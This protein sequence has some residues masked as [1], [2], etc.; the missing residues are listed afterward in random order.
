MVRTQRPHNRQ[1]T[2]ERHGHLIYTKAKHQYKNR[3]TRKKETDNAENIGKNRARQGYPSQG[4]AEKQAPQ[5]QKPSIP[6]SQN[7][8]RNGATKTAL[9]KREKISGRKTVGKNKGKWHSSANPRYTVFSRMTRNLTIFEEKRQK[10][11]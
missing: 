1:K 11:G 2:G 10:H 9:Q 7:G 3:Q 5:H 8:K 4:E 6:D